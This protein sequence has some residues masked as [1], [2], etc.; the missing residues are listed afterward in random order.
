M[1]RTSIPQQFS[2]IPAVAAAL[3]LVSVSACLADVFRIDS[4]A[5]W[6]S[7]TFPRG[8][9]VQNEDG[10]IGLGRIDRSINAV[11]D[12]RQ[13]RHLTRSSREPVPGGIRVVGSAEES[14]ENIIDGRADTWWQPP[15]DHVIEDWF[16]EVD[17]GRVVLAT[18]IRL[19]FPDTLGAR[20][21]RSFSVYTNDGV[22]AS[23]A[24]D[25]FQFSRAGRASEPNVDRVVEYELQ[26]IHAGGATGEHLVVSDTLDHAMVQYV[27]FVAEEQNVGAALAEI[28]VIGLGNNAVLG[29]VERGGGVRGGTDLSNLSTLIDGDKNSTWS[30]SG[31]NDWVLEGHWFEIDL[32]AT[33]WIDRAFMDVSFVR[34]FGSCEIS[35][36]DGTQARGVTTDR[37]RGNFDF[38]QLSEVDNT[39]SP[40]RRVFDFKF[41][42]RKTRYVFYHRLNFIRIAGAQGGT[43]NPFYSITEFM[44]LGDGYVAGA[45]M[46]SDFIDLGGTKSI[47]RLSWDADLPPETFVEIRSQTGDT[48]FIEEKFYNKN[49]V[50]ISQAQW[51]KLPKSQKQDVVE[52][53][54]K[55]SDWSGWSQVYDFPEE[56]FLSPTPRRFVQLQVRLGNDD[57]EVTPTLRSISL[58]FDNALVSGGVT[59][60]VLPRQVEFDSLQTFSYVLK[61]TF[62]FG[63]QGF[64]RVH[65]QTPA[66]VEEVSVRVG[67]SA[68]T[69]VAVT[70]AGDSLQV[71]LPE[72]VQRDSVEVL[73]QTRI[74]ANATAFNAWVSLV[75][76]GALQGVKPAEQHAATVFVPSVASGGN[77]IRSVDVT[78]LVTPNGDGVN[79]MASIRFLLAKVELTAPEVTI[80]DL[81]GRAVRVV[82]TGV[83]GYAWD[84]R[85]SAGRMLPPGVYLCRISVAADVGEHSVRRII[86][87]A[88]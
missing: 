53:Q 78:S 9:V 26:T 21:F 54:R 73:F 71:D 29:S 76:T 39:G 6:D 1:T 32:G 79:D 11:A 43:N 19:T 30:L 3:L 14:A 62:R 45:E 72:R 75:G 37:V 41:P 67:G 34:F 68:V 50:E 47:R 24:R 69:P 23:A 22:R 8:A 12:A 66:A 80:Y 77:L 7:W 63:D 4:K 18:K 25:V 57:P 82:A 46:E 84:G 17:L 20:P 33:Y 28:E 83:D 48:F 52:I 74:R 51:S 61:P 55:G 60:R 42:L 40:L 16:I 27:R 38:Q 49:G 2:Y 81:A 15:Q 13:F 31:P 87:L 59:S 58:H 56:V 85:D 44:L 64:D 10:S 5:N 36:S 35:T 86:N 88:Y 70:M 65:I